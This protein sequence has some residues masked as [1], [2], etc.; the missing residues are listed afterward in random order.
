[1]AIWK[2]ICTA[3]GALACAGIC[4]A[5]GGLAAPAI[6]GYSAV[7]GAAGFFIGDK[8]D[9]ESVER[10]KM[11]MQDQR[12]KQVVNEVEKQENDNKQ[13]EET[14]DVITGKLNGN[15][16]RENH[17]TDEYLRNQLIIYQSQ[18][19]SGKSRL[20]SLRKDVDKL[21]KELGGDSNNLISLLGLDKLSFTDKLMIAGG[22]VLVIWLLK[23]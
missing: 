7:A 12:Y 10:E 19:D 22:I 1:M 23:K 6:L 20:N 3:C 15:I 16:P 21:R 4:I 17:E 2:G 9:K 13:V 8:A 18:L 11:L 14:V 5:T